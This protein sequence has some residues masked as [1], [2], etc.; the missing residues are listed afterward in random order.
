MTRALVLLN[1]TIPDELRGRSSAGDARAAMDMCK[2]L[3]S[4]IVSSAPHSS[5]LLLGL[6][7]K[8]RRYWES[9]EEETQM[10]L[11]LITFDGSCS[12]LRQIEVRTWALETLH[13][14]FGKGML[15]DRSNP[16]P[17]D[18]LQDLCAS[19]LVH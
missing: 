12:M 13:K 3:V 16:I 2:T 7:D 8:G 1:A 17:S 15:D 19:C 10:V 14:C 4:L 5:E 6:V 18:W 11:S 9:L